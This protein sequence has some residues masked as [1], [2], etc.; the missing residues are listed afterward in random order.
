M[1][2]SLF[3]RRTAF[4]LCAVAL[5][6][7]SCSNNESGKTVDCADSDLTIDT[8][9]SN[10]STCNASDGEIEVE[11]TGGKAPYT[12]S[13]NGGAFVENAVFTGLGAGTFSLRVQDKNKCIQETEI[14][15]SN[16]GSDFEVAISGLDDAGCK[17]TEGAISGVASGGTGPYSYKLNDGTFGD[18]G[19]FSNLG[20]GTYTITAKDANNCT[21]TTV[22]T[23]ITSGISYQT[24]IKPLIANRCAHC[25]GPNG[26]KSDRDWTVYANV[27]AFSAGIKTRTGNGSMPADLA[28]S[29]GLPPEERDLI[30][31]WVD[32]GA[33]NN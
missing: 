5:V 32:D 16:P 3:V 12:Y 21:T 27:K 9:P 18:T 8:T 20:T 19:D 6:H 13:I 7:M 2:T 33:L 23:K 28:G 24:D 26:V 29:G 4:I 31:C 15:L 25:H 22:A 11:A 17:T 14:N 10:P 30:A 1:N